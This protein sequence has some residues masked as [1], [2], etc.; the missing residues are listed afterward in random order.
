VRRGPRRA[1]VAGVVVLATIAVGATPRRAFAWGCA[2]HAIV[3]RIAEWHL[4]AHA[5]K[6][7]GELLARNKIDPALKRYCTRITSDPLADGATWADDVREQRPETAPW[8]FVD[9]PRGAVQADV[10]GACPSRGCVTRA[11]VE[12]VARL[13]GHVSAASKAEALR[14]VAH[15]IADVHQPLHCT[16][17]GDRGGNCVPVKYFREAPWLGDPATG[18][19]TPNLHQVW[20]SRILDRELAARHRTPGELASAI[21]CRFAGAI[22]A[23]AKERIDPDAW[24]WEAHRQGEQVVY[25]KL[26]VPVPVVPGPD[27]ATCSAGDVTQRM[28]DLGLAID[29]PYQD[30]AFAVVEE[31]L[32][33]AGA[34][35]AAAL[36][37]VW[38]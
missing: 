3:A 26:A 27:A 10:A 11:I 4:S 23:W 36:N 37:D 19:Y 7:V 13:R 15:F 32:A 28:L 8:H 31:Q 20:D 9:I 5:R 35:L 34:R 25:G 38:P 17:N 30:A 1:I 24:A 2:G 6:R 33:R 22:R 14:Y 12:Q 21:D 29:Q 16:S 18:K